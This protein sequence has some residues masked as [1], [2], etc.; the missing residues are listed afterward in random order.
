MIKLTKT[1]NM[2]VYIN[3]SAIVCIEPKTNI[4][5]TDNLSCV[6]LL[7]KTS[8]YIVKESP[9]T[10]QSLIDAYQS[11]MFSSFSDEL[12]ENFRWLK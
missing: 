5:S 12:Y 4:D 8:H 11:R 9:E 2:P 7:E 1:N 3:P 10:I 6:Y